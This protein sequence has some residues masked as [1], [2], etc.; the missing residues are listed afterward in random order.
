MRKTQ[1][2]LKCG[3]SRGRGREERTLNLCSR[4]TLIV[5]GQRWVRHGAKGAKIPVLVPGGVAECLPP[6][7]QR[8]LPSAVAS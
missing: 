1:V 8:K 2:W 7:L 5:F 6:D 3:F 4:G